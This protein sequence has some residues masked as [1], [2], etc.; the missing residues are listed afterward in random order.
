[1]MD[2]TK[3]SPEAMVNLHCLLWCLQDDHPR[4]A[5]YYVDTLNA[6]ANAGGQQ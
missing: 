3:F 6:L 2:D 5:P 1:M 4:M